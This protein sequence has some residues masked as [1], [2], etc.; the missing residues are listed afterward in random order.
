VPGEQ[1]A[2][3]FAGRMELTRLMLDMAAETA[4]P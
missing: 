1:T 4:G 3:M 2:A